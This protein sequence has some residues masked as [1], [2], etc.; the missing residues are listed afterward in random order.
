MASHGF[1]IEDLDLTVVG[2]YLKSLLWSGNC[3]SLPVVGAAIAA[4]LVVLNEDTKVYIDFGPY[5]LEQLVV[6]SDSSST[7]FDSGSS[8]S[9]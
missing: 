3:M 9:E 8:E 2:H 7:S 6:T 5:S 1:R 4:F